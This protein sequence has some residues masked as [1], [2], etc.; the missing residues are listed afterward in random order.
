MKILDV[1]TEFFVPLWRR[2][3]VVA[4]CLGWALVEFIWGEAFWGLLMGG[5][6]AYCAREFFFVFA[7]PRAT[8]E[9][10]DGDD[11]T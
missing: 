1:Q 6:G 10:H 3:A 7:P 5:I 9:A 11:P 4:A 8:P 2:I